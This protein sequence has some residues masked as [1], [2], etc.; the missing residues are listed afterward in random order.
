MENIEIKLSHLHREGRSTEDKDP[1]RSVVPES[2]ISER[3]SRSGGKG[4]QNV[5]KLSTKAEVRWD[6]GSSQAFTDEEKERIKQVLRNR[7]NKEGELIIVSQE[8]RSQL[9]NRRL[10]IERLNEL[11]SSALTLEKERISTKPTH[12]SKERR[13]EEKKRQG[14]KKASRQHRD[15]I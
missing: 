2:E 8:E 5:N 7:I 1:L 14:E 11:V 15:I 6:I 13:L 10:A 4:G 12:A 9:Q 3:F